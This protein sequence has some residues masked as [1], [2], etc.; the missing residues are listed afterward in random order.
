[1]FN[2]FNRKF[3]DPVNSET[4][5]KILNNRVSPSLLEIGLEWNGKNQWIGASE[6]GIRKILKFQVGKGLMGTFVWGMCFDFLPILSGK[7]IVYQRTLKSAKPQLFEFSAA[8]D[9]F[10]SNKSDLE[11]GIAT[12][13]GERQCD[14][15]I[16]LLFKKRKD[17]IFN[18]LDLGSTVN[19]SLT[20]ANRQMSN[21]NYDIHWPNPKYVAAYL[22]AKN[23]NKKLGIELLEEIQSNRL[24]LENEIFEKIKKRLIEL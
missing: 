19:G 23:G 24:K 9:N 1:M 7:R 5:K 15:S 12:T 22:N 4:L 13:W 11:N 2:L 6:N 14:K 16:K 18:W 8:I 10:Q 20:I 21:E 3:P 17:E